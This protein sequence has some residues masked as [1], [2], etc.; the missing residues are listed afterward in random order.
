MLPSVYRTLLSIFISA[1]SAAPKAHAGNLILFGQTIDTS[2]YNKSC[3]HLRIFTIFPIWVCS[4]AICGMQIGVVVCVYGLGWGFIISFN[5]TT[6][7]LLHLLCMSLH[8][9]FGVFTCFCLW[10]IM[11]R[12]VHCIRTIDRVN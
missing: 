3:M 7:I 6:N 8:L 2:R 12:A 10:E 9:S 11:M 1:M 5:A 4:H